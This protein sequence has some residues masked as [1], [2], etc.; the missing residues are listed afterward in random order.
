MSLPG[1]TEFNTETRPAPQVNE[2]QATLPSY[3]RRVSTVWDVPPAE[4]VHCF[5]LTAKK[6]GTRWLTLALTSRAASAVDTPTFYQGGDVA[7]N[8]KLDLEKEE[9]V[10]EITIALYGRLSI[11]SHSTSNFLYASQTLYSA[12][13]SEPQNTH[14]A[15]SFLKRGVSIMSSITTNGIAERENYRLPPS[16]KDT[17]A[18]VDVQYLL[19]VRVNRGGFKSGDKLSVPLTY[20]PLAR[21]SPPSI[22]RQL[23]YREN[24]PLVGPDGDPDGWKALASTHIKGFTI[25]AYTTLLKVHVSKPLSYTRG[26]PIH[27]LISISCSNGQLL[28]L[29]GPQSVRLA[30]VQRITF[31]DATQKARFSERLPAQ[32]TVKAFERASASWWKFP[33]P[34]SASAPAP[35]TKTFAGELLI[36]EDLVPGCQ[37]LHYGHEYELCLYP[38]NVVGFTPST[39]QKKPLLSERVG[40]V[41]AFAQ[42]PRPL[43]YI[44]PRY[45]T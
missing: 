8:V 37:I 7:G 41:T 3:S 20:I 9:M 4:Q 35:T 2:S 44:P 45:D 38:F 29:I 16:F 12:A 13:A 30:L 19:I 6:T 28:D 36:P 42:A 24:T 21:P 43:S 18:N 10:D 32:L 14:I 40:I 34:T 15:T 11:F 33:S 25:W 31:G 39:P 23:A 1:Y 27:L 26:A 17:E 22:L 5:Y